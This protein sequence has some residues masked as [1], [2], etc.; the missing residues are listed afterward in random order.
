[1]CF[2][3]LP[4]ED[5]DKSLRAS[6][7]IFQG[8]VFLTL[9]DSYVFKI[10]LYDRSDAWLM[11]QLLELSCV[12]NFLK[13]CLSH[14]MIQNQLMYSILDGTSCGCIVLFKMSS[15]NTYIH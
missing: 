3:Q 2:S 9:K 7:N 1:M 14:R 12:V 8:F 4:H 10:F 13:P 15:V 11:Q 5:N 6:E